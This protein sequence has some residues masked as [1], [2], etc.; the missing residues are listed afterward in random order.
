V[1]R[2]RIY[3]DHNASAPLRA[4]ALDAMLRVL[5][6]VPGNPSSVH[7][8]GERAREALAQA[9][10]RVAALLG[11]QPDEIVFTSGAT[12]ANNAVFASLASGSAPAA[13]ATSAVEHPS[14]EQPL[15]RL[16]KRGW[17][18]ARHPVTCEG[19]L[20]AREFLASL[21]ADVQLVSLIAANNETGVLFPI[22]AIADGLRERGIALHLVATQW[23]GKLPLDA[24]KLS[25]D[26]LACSAH[27][28]GGP[29]GVGCLFVRRGV[30]FEPA[31]L[32][33]SQERRRRAGT[34][35]LAGIAGFGAACEAAQQSLAAESQRVA[36]LRD[37][38]WRGLRERVPGVLR[39][40]G[41][42]N[43]LPNTLN[44]AFPAARGELLLQ[45]LDLDGVAVS[46]GAACA[47]GSLA[48]S[49]VLLAMG[50]GAERAAESL[51][52]SLG[53][54]TTADEIERVLA[55]VPPIVARVRASGATR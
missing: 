12:E 27:K 42:Q 47:S 29:K 10:E 22:A 14:V 51:R 31:L 37:R 48:P 45:A 4:E 9:R 34:E 49:P 6:D 3:L 53:P 18:V 55:L 13:I 17:R 40:G 20:D 1:T 7:A 8:E 15:G 41:A 52:F 16:E 23:I 26:S 44:A 21:C 50:L 28:L 11:A 39:N 2:A 46:A 30:A 54:A 32:G 38:L 5:R 33:G 25:V 19:E 36:A 43:V 24:R 35:N